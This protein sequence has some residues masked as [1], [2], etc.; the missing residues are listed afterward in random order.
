MPASP[1]DAPET[2]YLVTAIVSTYKS[3]RFMRG[4]LEDLVAQTLGERLEIIV[5]DSASPEG[6][7]AIVREFQQHHNNIRYIRT[8]EREGVYA[9]W[10]RGVELAQGKYLTNANTDDRHRADALERMAETL[11]A[12]PDIAL[13]YADLLITLNENETL[14]ACT[15]C[16]RYNWREWD[17]TTLLEEG[18]FMGPQPMWRRT[19]H[20][21][22]GLF[23]PSFVTS[24]DYEFWLRVSQTHA[25]LH[26]PEVLGL[27]LKSPTSVEHANRERGARENAHIFRTYR[28][29]EAA[30]VIHGLQG[31]EDRE[32]ALGLHNAMGEQ[33]F[34]HRRYRQ[35]RQVFEQILQHHPDAPEPMNNLAVTLFQL[36]E[37][38]RAISCLKGLVRIEPGR[39]D[40]WEN[41]MD[42]LLQAGWTAEA[43]KVASEAR[44]HFPTHARFAEPSL[45][46]A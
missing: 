18:C 15:P 34:S 12:N 14:N 19:L 16:G 11:D 23:D 1:E 42:C 22:F 36:G 25:F 20:D 7:G 24:G 32:R 33:L 10:N 40:A 27:Y 17:R 26:I 38:E 46:C 21:V 39:L 44:K 30:G 31:L 2:P 13:V 43:S 9:A 4:C 28:S 8:P 3:E 45:Q 29:A 37:T 6:E 41:L 35:A 5:I